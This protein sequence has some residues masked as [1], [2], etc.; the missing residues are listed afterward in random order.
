MYGMQLMQ[1]EISLPTDYD[2]GIDPRGW[3]LVQF[4]LWTTPP[5]E[6]EQ[7]YEVLHVSAPVRSSA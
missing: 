7:R 5:R 6:D 2:M 3:Q 1:Y 4:T